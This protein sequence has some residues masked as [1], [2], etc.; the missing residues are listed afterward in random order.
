MNSLLKHENEENLAEIR[1]KLDEK[2]I[3]VQQLLQK[4]RELNEQLEVEK[5]LPKVPAEDF[6]K[7]LEKEI[8]EMKLEDPKGNFQT[9]TQNS[10]KIETLLL[11]IMHSKKKLKK[12]GI[13]LR[14]CDNWDGCE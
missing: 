10:E 8:L 14:S 3:F 2:E 6:F 9:F 4:C 13:K 7:R 12:K 1:K 5:P 11:G